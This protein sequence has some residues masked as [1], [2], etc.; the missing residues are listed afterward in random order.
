MHYS[1]KWVWRYLQRPNCFHSVC[2]PHV[3][4]P[5]LLKTKWLLESRR[6]HTSRHY[7]N[8]TMIQRVRV[9]LMYLSLVIPKL[10][11]HQQS[12]STKWISTPQTQDVR[13]HIHQLYSERAAFGF[14]FCLPHQISLSDCPTQWNH[15][16]IAKGETYDYL[17]HV[18]NSKIHASSV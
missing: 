16:S 18:I 7:P 12:V 14:G 5:H 4:E 13:N 17:N 2:T 11:V 3:R 15:R 9:Q 1:N 10:S 6:F 8:K